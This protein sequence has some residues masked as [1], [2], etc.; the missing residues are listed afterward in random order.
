VSETNS[1]SP[2][3][4]IRWSARN[5]PKL[6]DLITRGRL[7]GAILLVAFLFGF[8]F[9]NPSYRLMSVAISTGISAITLYGLSVIFGQVGIMSVGH[10]AL[11]GCG[12][13]T[14]ALLAERLGVGFWVST[15]IAMVATAAVA[16]L[17]GL[18][19]L[20]V[21]G[22]HFIIISFA[23]GSLFSIVM[24]NGGSFTGSAA[25][26]DLGTVPSVL[27]LHFNKVHDFYLLV[28]F[29]V[30][31]SILAT[32][33]ISILPYGRTLR[34]IRENEPLAMAIGIDAPGQKIIAFMISGLYAGLAGSLQAHYLLH[35]SPLL[36]GSFPSV[37]LALMVMLGGPRMLLGPL[38][39]AIIVYFLPEMLQL[40]PVDSRIVY[41]C[42]L[43]AVIMLMPGG[44]VAGMV[45]GWRL[46]RGR[47]LRLGKPAAP[48]GPAL[49]GEQSNDRR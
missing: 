23:F 27:G 49:A 38:A 2:A 20:R 14:V 44:A 33:L 36:Y 47:M 9:L 32:F 5:E 15:P 18:A 48:A 42:G 19:S 29:F 35:V 41:G 46:V 12:A 22:H 4:G 34:A 26:L 28:A 1:F 30:L 8:P 24:T 16:G 25:G 11:M 17:L 3:G 6:I 37:Y 10:A 39:G 21:A 31:L 13:Y 7:I 43:I 40:D 45:E